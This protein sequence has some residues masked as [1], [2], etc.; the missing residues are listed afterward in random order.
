V[1]RRVAAYV[2]HFASEPAFDIYHAQDGISGNALATLVARGAIP[3]FVRTVHHLDD[4]ADPELAAL[5]DRSIVASAQ[6]FA[7]SHLWS[8]RLR[9]RYGIDAR[10][11]PNGVDLERFSPVTVERRRELRAE[12]GFGAAPVF[13]TIGGIEARKNTLALLEAFALV[14]LARP[15]ARLI[16]AGG[17]SV[18]EHGAYRRA[19]DA[20][21]A[22]LGLSGDEITIAGVRTDAEIVALLRAA[23][24]FVFPSLVE[25][26]GLAVLEALACG[27]PVI[28]SAL[29][30]FTEYLTSR[31]ALL[32]DPHDPASIAA[33]MLHGIRP[34]V[35]RRLSAR[36]PGV[37]SAFTWGASAR[38][39]LAH[40]LVPNRAP[41]ETAV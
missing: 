30:P 19:F 7:V 29:A 18:L 17:A 16:V 10:V 13:L 41:Y 15:P 25:G 38:A 23:D 40:Y 21:R 1:R 2:E 32:A 24:A 4:F 35:R 26:F 8:D 36:G 9:E 20:R 28:A 14:R 39:H 34:H 37:A 31:T 11:V 27:T 12:M 3:S 22:E 6:H 5:H 33:A